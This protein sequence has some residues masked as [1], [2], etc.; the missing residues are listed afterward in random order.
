VATAIGGAVAMGWALAA[1][2]G[3]VELGRPFWEP[4]YDP[5]P[6]PAL[7]SPLGGLLLGGLLLG[8]WQQRILRPAPQ[9]RWWALVTVASGTIA[10]PVAMVGGMAG[11]ELVKLFL[12]ADPTDD[13]FLDF[14]LYLAAALGIGLGWTVVAVPTG[15]LLQRILSEDGGAPAPAAG[16]APRWSWTQHARRENA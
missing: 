11:F 5:A 6:L 13:L 8:I 4:G 3:S 12:D 7:A 16:R 9:A 14:H 10:L 1:M 2:V 15:V